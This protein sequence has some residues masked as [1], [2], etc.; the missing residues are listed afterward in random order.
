MRRIAS[1]AIGADRQFASAMRCANEDDSFDPRIS[2]EREPAMEKAAAR[3]RFENFLCRFAQ[4]SLPIL[5]LESHDLH[6]GKNPAQTVGNQHVAL[7]IRIKL[8]HFARASRNLRA[9]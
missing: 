7:V 8:V 6:M 1:S 2:V 9:E 4:S 5:A 3:Q